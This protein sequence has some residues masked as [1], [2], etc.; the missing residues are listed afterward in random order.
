VPG[1]TLF[2]RGLEGLGSIPIARS[3]QVIELI[4]SLRDVRQ[5]D[6]FIRLLNQQFQ[7]TTCEL[8]PETSLYYYRSRYYD[9]S[10][11]RFLI[12]D[13]IYFGGGNNSYNYASGDF[14]NFLLP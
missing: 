12:Q 3:I 14:W 1:N 10:V 11:G 6:K 2:R 8:D 13:P 4:H 9:P 7:Y 5:A